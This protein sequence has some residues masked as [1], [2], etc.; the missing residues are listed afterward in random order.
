MYATVEAVWRDDHLEPLE[1]IKTGEN[2]RY[3]VTV[4]EES[5]S[6]SDFSTEKG[7][8]GFAKAQTILKSYTGSLGDA[9]IKEREE[10]SGE[11]VS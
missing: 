7:S 8:F 11:T 2:I 9:V 3:L 6:D 1:K 4:I 10:N 5:G